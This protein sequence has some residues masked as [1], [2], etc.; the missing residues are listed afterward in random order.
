MAGAGMMLMLVGFGFKI[1][2]FPF[3]AWTPDVYQGAPGPTTGF[4]AAAV[5]AATFAALLRVLLVAFDSL[6]AEWAF[7]LYYLAIA[8]MIFGNVAALVQNRLKRLLAYSS[9]AHAGYL[10]VGV[11]AMLRQEQD[12]AQAVLFY[13]AAYT[14]MTIGAFAVVSH[15]SQAR[16]DADDLNG[17]R[18]LARRHPW[19]AAALTIFLLSM[20]GLPPFLGFVGKFLLFRAAV[21]AGMTQLAVIGVLTSA[22]S[23]YY[24]IRVIYLMYMTEAEEG[25]PAASPAAVD[26]P[27]RAALA[28][29]S[30]LVVILGVLP[31]DLIGWAGQG[32]A[33]LLGR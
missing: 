22:I 18:G 33:R 31:Q 21:K 3:Q 29:T 19:L 28:A 20:V 1:A 30:L 26:W 7:A 12:G 24:Y 11:T 2:A 9:I 14:L 6:R 27:G 4:M 32:A 13:L 25:A 8:T 15:L 17:Y 23:V 10:L 5:K 16:A